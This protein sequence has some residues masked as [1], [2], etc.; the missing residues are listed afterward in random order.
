MKAATLL[1]EL[2]PLIHTDRVRRMV[3][4]GREARTNAA[5]AATLTA[6]EQGD[7]YQ[8]SLALYACYGSAD[9]ALVLRTLADP[10]RSVRALALSLV[11]LACDDA[12]ALSALGSLPARTQ[13][14]L[15]KRLAMR[16]R[17]APVDAFL[18]T[19]PDDQALTTIVAALSG[20]LYWHAASLRPTVAAVIAAL[21]DDPRTASWQATLAVS[22][23]AWPDT[24]AVLRRLAAAD[25]LHAEATVAAVANVANAAGR[26]AAG[27]AELE[28]AFRAEANPHLRRIALAALIGL[29]QPPRG[30]NAERLRLLDHYRADPAP[31]VAA[32]AWC[33]FPN[34]ADAVSETETP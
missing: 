1:R 12:Q 14:S 28:V 16:K 29:S 3:A 26:S 33:T 17:F 25:E 18:A 13:R 15:L 30:W 21:A 5:V 24:I 31:L 32:V 7:V 9:G 4:L 19:L 6:L 2:E 27:L 8:R 11:A 34:S 20:R 23:L 10:S 22:G